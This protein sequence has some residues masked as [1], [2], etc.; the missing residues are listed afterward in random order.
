MFGLASGQYTHGGV[1]FPLS[2]PSGLPLQYLPVHDVIQQVN[3]LNLGGGFAYSM[4]DSLDLFASFTRQVTGRNGHV[5][6]HGVTVGTSWSFS[7]RAKV[8]G[9]G[10]GTG[11]GAPR[12]EYA[13]L[14]GKQ[15]GSLGRCICQKSGM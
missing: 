12:S 14:N 9:V 7:R 3:A 10:A 13:R 8:D 6:N 1:D 5:L 11:A 2:G 4:T 15:E